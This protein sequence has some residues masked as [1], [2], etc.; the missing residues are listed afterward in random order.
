MVGEV[1]LQVLLSQLPIGGALIICSEL[2]LCLL[3]LRRVHRRRHWR[4]S[5]F[6]RLAGLL[7]GLARGSSCIPVRVRRCRVQT[8]RLCSFCH[9]PGGQGPRA[10]IASRCA[11]RGTLIGEMARAQH[12]QAMH[13]R[14]VIAVTLKP[15]KHNPSKHSADHPLKHSITNAS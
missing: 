2:G 8:G 15:C 12:P 1:Q 14:Y 7:S 3:Q 10:V 5:R 6:G 13:I 4:R 9:C 11:L